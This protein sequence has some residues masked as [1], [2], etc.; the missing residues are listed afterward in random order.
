[1]PSAGWSSLPPDV[2]RLIAGCLLDTNDVNYYMDFR[3]VCPSWR[4]ATDDPKDDPTGLRFRPRRWIIIDELFQNDSRLLVNTATGRVVR[5]ELPLLNR[6]FFIA[7][8]HGGF[9]VLANKEPPHAALVLNPFTGHI[10][11]YKAPVTPW[12]RDAAAAVSASSPAPTLVFVFGRRCV[13]H[14]VCAC[15]SL[16][17]FIV[18]VCLLL[19]LAK[20]IIL[21]ESAGELLIIIKLKKGVE[22]FRMDIERHI[23]EHAE[24]IGNRAIFLSDYKCMAVAADKFPSIGANCIYYAKSLDLSNDMYKYNLKFG[25]EERISEVMYGREE[26]TSGPHAIIEFLLFESLGFCRY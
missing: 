23:I 16:C 3:A 14:E 13:Q 24:N 2:V 26:E 12:M 7:T 4:S 9:F 10:I 15:Q 20:T 5:K 21:V 6:Y 17:E 8:T 25:R 22:V 19:R 1:M 11:R 18:F